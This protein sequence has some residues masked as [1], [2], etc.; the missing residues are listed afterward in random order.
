MLRIAV[1]VVSKKAA[2]HSPSPSPVT[3]HLVPTR[4]GHL[5][6]LYSPTPSGAPW[7]TSTPRGALRGLPLAAMSPSSKCRLSRKALDW[8]LC[9]GGTKM[10]P[11]A[12]D[13]RREEVAPQRRPGGPQKQR[14]GESSWSFRERS[15]GRLIIRRRVTL[16]P[17]IFRL[18]AYR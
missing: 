12:G 17:R 4:R 5:G 9:S 1:P 8:Q 14:S 13:Q 18:P 6:P 15:R 7:K 2:A 16:R 3:I 11:C 10:L